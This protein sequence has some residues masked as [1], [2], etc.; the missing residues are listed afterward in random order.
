MADISK[1]TL[2]NGSTYDL[3]DAD[4]V[5]SVTYDST[6]KKITKTING[7]TTDV[8]TAATLGAA[9][10]SKLTLTLASSSWS[11]NTITVTATGVTA[12][13]DVFITPAA[14]SVTDYAAAQIY[15]SAQGADSLTFTCVTA[16]ENSITVNVMIFL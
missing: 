15:C 16:P 5:N 12:S 4:A 6:N 3:K 10:R 2:P 7:T 14:A 9:G 11:N 1:I 8:V 13:N